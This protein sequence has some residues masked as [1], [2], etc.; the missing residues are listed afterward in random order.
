MRLLRGGGAGKIFQVG[1]QPMN[2]RVEAYY[3]AV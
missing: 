3:N 1:K 2:A